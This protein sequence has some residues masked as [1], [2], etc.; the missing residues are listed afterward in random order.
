[1]LEVEQPAPLPLSSHLSRPSPSLLAGCSYESADKT[2]T[3]EVKALTPP[4]VTPTNPAAQAVC[5][6]STANFTFDVAAGASTTS[7]VVSGSTTCSVAAGYKVT[8][9]SVGAPGASVTVAAK[10]GDPAAGDDCATDPVAVPLTVTTDPE[11]TITDV[12]ATPS[13]ICPTATTGSV[14]YTVTLSAAPKTLTGSLVTSPGGVAVTDA[15]IKCSSAVTG[16]AKVWSVTCTGVPVG[17]YAVKVD[18]TSNLGEPPARDFRGAAG[19]GAE[20]MARCRPC[21]ALRP[22]AAPLCIPPHAPASP[23]PTAGCPYSPAP[24]TAADAVASVA[25]YDFTVDAGPDTSSLACL[26]SRGATTMTVTLS[27]ALAGATVTAVPQAPAP[28]AC[29]RTG[30]A[31]V[32]FSCTGLPAGNVN[33]VVSAVENGEGGGRGCWGLAAEARPAC[34]C[35]TRPLRPHRAPASPAGAPLPTLPHRLH[36]HRHRGGC[37][38]HRAL[39]LHPHRRLLGQP[40]RGDL[41]H[42]PEEGRRLPPVVGLGKG[43]DNMWVRWRRGRARHRAAWLHAPHRPAAQ[44]APGSHNSGA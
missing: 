37:C 35:R 18:V 20:G 41:P 1:M 28:A 11:I 24:L 40:R 3:A 22:A 19:H 38:V 32:V 16:D 43:G 29:T 42:C 44:A 10:Y 17:S 36:R 39:L 7:L 8:C 30:A 21:P 12:K 14:A 23:L 9:T 25:K 33:I 27:A 34:C 5:P 2:K 13:Q 4:T 15:L 6:G 26:G 31:G